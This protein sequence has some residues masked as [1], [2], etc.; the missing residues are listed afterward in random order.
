MGNATFSHHS[1]LSELVLTNMRHDAY[2]LPSPAYPRFAGDPQKY[3]PLYSN[4]SCT[5]QGPD[6]HVCCDVSVFSLGAPYYYTRLVELDPILMSQLQ[7]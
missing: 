3:N 4:S 2:S 7:S 1:R 6:P 5:M